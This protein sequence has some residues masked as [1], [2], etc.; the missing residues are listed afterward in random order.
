L[1]FNKSLQKRDGNCHG[2][3][4]S[5][6]EM[7]LKAVGQPL[8]TAKGHKKAVGKCLKDTGKPLSIL[9]GYGKLL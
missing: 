2:L 4:D 9:K 7:L 6:W 3:A 5:Q 8:A 1:I